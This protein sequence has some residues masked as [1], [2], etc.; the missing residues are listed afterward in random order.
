MHNFR[1]ILSVLFILMLG[2]SPAGKIS[3]TNINDSGFR[4]PGMMLYSLPQT[5]LDV[6][7]EAHV[8]EIIPGPYRQYAAEYLESG[9]SFKTEYKWT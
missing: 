3:V 9:C 1:F 7:V 5:V 6:T 2:C 8:T 4:Q